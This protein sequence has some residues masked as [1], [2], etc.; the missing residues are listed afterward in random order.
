MSLYR[1]AICASPNVLKNKEKD[2]FSYKKAIAG[3][4]VFGA[5]GAVAGIDG[6]T[7]EVYSCPDCGNTLPHPKWG[8]IDT[9]GQLVIPCIWENSFPSFHEG[10]AYVKKGTEYFY[11]DTQGNI[12]IQ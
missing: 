4:V 5:I 6:K 12:V 2:G 11:I 1:C 3:T 9:T 8:F 10:L 7:K